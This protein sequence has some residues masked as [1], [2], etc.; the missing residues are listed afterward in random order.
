MASECSGITSET[1]NDH[2]ADM[3]MFD[4]LECEYPLPVKVDRGEPFQTKDTPAQF[5]DNYKIKEDG[6]LW[7]EKYDTE[8]RSDPNASGLD[9]FRGCAT[10]VNKR[11]EQCADFTGE[12]AFYGFHNEKK[13]EGWVEFSAYFNKGLLVQINTIA[14]RVR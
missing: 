12:I 3:G 14:N 5:L 7:H 13:Q 2:E 6:T 10:R 1:V 4:N 8:D 9:A 11:W